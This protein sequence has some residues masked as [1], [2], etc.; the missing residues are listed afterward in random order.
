MKIL[1]IAP[2]PYFSDRGTHIRIFE[3]VSGLRK[4]GHKILVTTYHLG[5]DIHKIHSKEVKIKRILPILFWYKKVDAGANWQKCFLD[6]QLL[7]RTIIETIKFKPQILH[8]HLHEGILIGFLTK[9]VLFWRKFKLV[10]DLHGTLVNE[11]ISCGYLKNKLAK[12]FFIKLEQF[13]NSKPDI[14]ITSSDE[15]L[16]YIQNKKAI[17]VVDGIDLDKFNL[18]FDKNAILEKFKL[19]KDKLL[20]IYTGAFHKN[21]GQTQLI[22]LINVTDQENVHFVLAGAPIK[23]IEE[24]L[25]SKS[26]VSYIDNLRY[27]DIPELLAI[28]HVALDP[29]GTDTKQASGKLLQYMGATI[30]IFC[31][32]KLNNRAYLGNDYP[33]C[34]SNDI[35]TMKNHL[36]GLIDDIELRAKSKEIISQKRAAFSWKNSINIIN[37]I[38]ERLTQ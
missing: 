22:E 13:I 5:K 16:Q 25:R 26:N 24:E 18:E 1:T 17:T 21:K 33:Y 8:C 35:Q 12:S 2:T 37:R 30:P 7:I 31:F 27:T 9:K 20:I 11:M 23:E 34:K 28:C 4:L 19:P 6:F 29:K 32:D 3:Q 14:I 38:Y 10:G 15:N 36:Q